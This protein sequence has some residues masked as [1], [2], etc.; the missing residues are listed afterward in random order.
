MTARQLT[1]RKENLPAR[2]EIC[3]QSDEFDPDT[4]ECRRCSNLSLQSVD[5]GVKR[6]ASHIDIEKA[7]YDRRGP[8]T[9][10]VMALFF[11]II[12][13]IPGICI[14]PVGPV[15]GI[16][17]AILGSRELNAIKKGHSSREGQALAKISISLGI[18]SSLF[19]IFLAMQFCSTN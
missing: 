1:I 11:A 3:H 5:S 9:R 2:C 7:L 16:L 13:F 8:S 4:L 15:L 18:G 6:T 17:A 19:Y 10:V 14:G 12:A